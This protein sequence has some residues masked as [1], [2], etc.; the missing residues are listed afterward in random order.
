MIGRFARIVFCQDW[1]DHSYR[2]YFDDFRALS[3]DNFWL[4]SLEG[5]RAC[6]D[7]KIYS[8][9]R[10]TSIIGAMLWLMSTAPGDLCTGPNL[11][12]RH[13]GVCR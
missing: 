10:A 6:A 8:F 1:T 3:I 9:K 12:I 13:D 11:R 5:S 2:K 7:P 4:T